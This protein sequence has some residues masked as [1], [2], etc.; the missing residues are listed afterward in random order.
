MKE[1]H[2]YY[3]GKKYDNLF[4]LFNP[5]NKSKETIT[6]NF[7]NPNYFYCSG[8]SIPIISIYEDGKLIDQSGPPFPSGT[9]VKPSGLP[10]SPL[11]PGG[12]PPKPPGPRPPSPK[13]TIPNPTR[14]GPKP[15][16]PSTKFDYDKYPYLKKF[17]G[18]DNRQKFNCGR[19]IEGTTYNCPI[20]QPTYQSMYSYFDSYGQD[21]IAD[22]SAY[23]SMS[24][25]DNGFGDEWNFKCK[26]PSCDNTNGPPG[27][28]GKNWC[29]GK[30]DGKTGDYGCNKDFPQA[31]S[32]LG[33]LQV[34]GLK[35]KEGRQVDG[36]WFAATNFQ[37][38]QCN[39]DGNAYIQSWPDVLGKCYI[40]K[41]QTRHSYDDGLNRNQ[42][43]NLKSAKDIGIVVLNSGSGGFNT[44]GGKNYVLSSGMSDCLNGGHK[45][46]DGSSYC[47]NIAEKKLN[48]DPDQKLLCSIANQNYFEVMAPPR[49]GMKNDGS[50]IQKKWVTQPPPYL[51]NNY[52]DDWHK[53]N[54]NW[55][56][57]NSDNGSGSS[58]WYFQVEPVDCP[59]E[60]YQT[61]VDNGVTLPPK[62][63]SVEEAVQRSKVSKIQ[64]NPYSLGN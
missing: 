57:W 60:V 35:G 51:E 40:G 13:P 54:D 28:R 10:F 26:S 1:Y 38:K 19:N 36:G 44:D 20:N 37:H 50:F 31:F 25:I 52:K 24:W 63:G 18:D 48:A 64:G 2:P 43:D 9:G 42:P 7:I 41:A 59:K 4:K 53:W 30:G 22:G 8:G 56:A 17:P 39:R 11:G 6:E 61:L 15:P 14:P 49:E 45:N 34:K 47:K 55:T 5:I 58:N 16:S 21:G 46:D 3:Y 27:V 33:S 62:F 23:S 12:L 29:Q 32:K